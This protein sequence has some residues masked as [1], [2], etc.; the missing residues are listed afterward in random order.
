MKLQLKLEKV[1]VVLILDNI[2]RVSDM[3]VCF[4]SSIM[5]R[6]QLVF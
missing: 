3:E 1:A 4:Q 2:M 6:Y 5:S